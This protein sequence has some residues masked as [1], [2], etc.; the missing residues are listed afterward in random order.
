MPS[1][2]AQSKHP[3]FDAAVPRYCVVFRNPKS[4]RSNISKKLI[5]EIGAALP[6][7]EII[8]V[9]TSPD[10][11]NAN[12]LLVEA[13][14]H[15]LGSESLICILG[16]D[17]TANQIISGLLASTVL[18]EAQKRTP[19]LPLWT[20]NATDLAHMLNGTMLRRSVGTILARA[21]QVPIY[22][23]HCK[24][25][26]T[27]EDNSRQEKHYAIC[28]AGFGATAFAAM[29]LNKP[30]HRQSKLHALPGGKLLQTG[31]TVISA[32]AGAPRFAVREQDDIHVVYERTFSNGSRMAKLK[33]LP[34]ELTDEMFY[35]NT[36]EHKRLTAAIPKLVEATRRSVSA[37]FLR[38]YA[39]FTT[40]EETWGQFD[41]EPLL[42]PAH[43]KVEVQLSNEPFIA[44]TANLGKEKR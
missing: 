35:L 22:P 32:L 23:L 27:G 11:H 2:A 5:R 6:N 37:K 25:S 33:Y 38:N 39:H 30:A 16:G 19:V 43:T 26:Q 40:Q 34:L 44:V 10:G 7:A 9:E 21:H 8:E 31:L 14:A 13:Q 41:G 12:Q 4:T 1:M 20:G 24:L 29:S 28:Y 18:T 36:L 17:G 3:R 15:H 42:I